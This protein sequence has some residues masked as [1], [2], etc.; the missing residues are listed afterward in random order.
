MYL[1]YG[2]AA[3]M[4]TMAAAALAFG[5]WFGPQ[6]WAGDRA[7][8]WGTVLPVAIGVFC[9]ASLSIGA[10]RVSFWGVQLIREARTNESDWARREVERARLDDGGVCGAQ[11]VLIGE[12]AGR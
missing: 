10:A 8:A 1:V 6:M 7:A 3:G 2:V 5:L 11:Q 9:T 4:F 12:P